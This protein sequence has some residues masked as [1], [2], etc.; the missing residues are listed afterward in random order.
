MKEV[1][2]TSDLEIGWGYV[3]QVE[4]ISDDRSTGVTWRR[5]VRVFVDGG[6]GGRG[7]ADGEAG[8]E[9]GGVPGAGKVS[10]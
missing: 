2:G 8:S 3:K 10:A 5:G 1:C 4:I 6:S 7:Q 9:A